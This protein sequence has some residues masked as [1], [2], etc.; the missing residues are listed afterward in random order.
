MLISPT[1]NRRTMLWL[2]G[3]ALAA[4]SLSLALP[5]KSVAKVLDCLPGSLSLL[6]LHNHLFQQARRR[7]QAH[8]DDRR[9][10]QT[11]QTY[12]RAPD[13]PL[14]LNHFEHQVRRDF[15]AGRVTVVDGWV[16]AETELALLALVKRSL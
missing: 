4:V 1:S 10:Y 13:S 11:A 15:V 5:G 8:P 9:L 14:A 6:P 3:S 16:V 12:L 7:M 2:M